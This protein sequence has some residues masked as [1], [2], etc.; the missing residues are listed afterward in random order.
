MLQHRTCDVHGIRVSV[1]SD[2]TDFL[3]L[4]DFMLGAFGSSGETAESL[5]VRVNLLPRAWLAPAAV[6]V[7]REGNEER[8][9]TE[10]FLEGTIA[11]FKADKYRIA[12]HDGR[13][14]VVNASFVLDRR[15]RLRGHS[16]GPPP[17]GEMFSLY[18][19]GVEEPILLKLE[20]RGNVLLHSAV[21]S[22]DGRAVVL[23]GLNGSGK[24]SLCASLLDR[25]KY[26]SD[27]FAA[28]DGEQILGFPCALRV[29]RGISPAEQGMPSVYGRVLRRVDPAKTVLRAKPHALVFL[30]LGSATSMKPIQPEEAFDRLARVADMVHEFPE[31]TYLG[32]LAPP[33]DLRRVEAL[34][35]GVQSYRLVMSETAE[36]REH[37][38]A[39]VS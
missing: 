22:S 24:S 28:W 36:A 21:A 6:D 32:P 15:S 20:Q 2:W 31:H 12:Y 1:S 4:A 16:G 7:K 38:L 3:T 37:V 27:N 29:P 5:D 8:L 33:R 17:W 39:L 19:L 23:I 26:L 35:R 30:S 34:A 11:R 9:G 14:A 13:D 10:E 18:R 25:M